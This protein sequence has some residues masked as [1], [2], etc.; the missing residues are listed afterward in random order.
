[1]TEP[2]PVQVDGPVLEAFGRFVTAWA[3]IDRMITSAFT[4]MIRAERGL[5]FVVTQNVMASTVQGWLRTTTNFAFGSDTPEVLE[6]NAVLAHVDDIRAERN[7]LI[8]GLWQRGP[9]AN[10][11]LVQTVRLERREV[12]KEELITLADVQEL[13]VDTIHLT[14]AL[15]AAFVALGLETAPVDATPHNG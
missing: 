6:L 5:A 7:A 12:L 15:S 1:M 14:N 8:H 13:Y 11:A 9:E 2:E 10:T 4:N 3:F